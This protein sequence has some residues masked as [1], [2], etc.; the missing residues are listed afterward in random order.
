[1][2]NDENILGD[3]V[4][5]PAAYAISREDAE[6]LNKTPPDYSIY[7]HLCKRVH[8][9]RAREDRGNSHDTIH[10][11]IAQTKLDEF[12]DHHNKSLVDYIL[13]G[14][15]TNE[16]QTEFVKNE[17]IP[18]CVFVWKETPDEKLANGSSRNNDSM[19]FVESIF[20]LGVFNPKTVKGCYSTAFCK[21][22][23]VCL[24][25]KFDKEEMNL[26][27]ILLMKKGCTQ[28]ATMA[29]I[30]DEIYKILGDSFTESRQSILP[31][32][33]KWCLDNGIEEEWNQKFQKILEL[34][35]AEGNMFISKSMK[36]NMNSKR[37]EVKLFD[38]KSQTSRNNTWCSYLKGILSFKCLLIEFLKD[39]VFQPI[40]P[41]SDPGLAFFVSKKGKIVS[42]N[43]RIAG[44]GTAFLFDT[45]PLEWEEIGGKY[46]VVGKWDRANDLLDG[47]IDLNDLE[48]NLEED[49]FY[50]EEEQEYDFDL[51][52]MNMDLDEMDL[53]LDN[54]MEIHE[55]FAQNDLLDKDPNDEDFNPLDSL[56]SGRVL[57]NDLVRERMQNKS[58]DF[59]N[60]LEASIENGMIVR[61]FLRTSQ[62]NETA[63]GCALLAYMINGSFICDNLIDNTAIE[64]ILDTDCPSIIHD[65][66]RRLGVIDGDYMEIDAIHEHFI[67]ERENEYPT[68]KRIGGAIGGNILRSPHIHNA[69]Q[70]FEN[71]QGTV[72]AA[73][74]FHSH[75]VAIA[76]IE[77]GNKNGG[78]K[79]EY[80]VIDTLPFNHDGDNASRTRCKDIASLEIFLSSLGWSKLSN[81]QRFLG[82]MQNVEDLDEDI[83]PMEDD[84]RNFSLFFYNRDTTKENSNNMKIADNVDIDATDVSLKNATSKKKTKEC[85]GKKTKGGSGKKKKGG[86]GKKKKGGSGKKKKGGSGKKKK[87]VI[88]DLT[89]TESDTDM[90]NYS[91]SNHTADMDTPNGWTCDNCTYNLN[92]EDFH[93]CAMCLKRRVI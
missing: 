40:S 70:E 73:L 3:R 82:R 85:S 46:V 47:E 48:F 59:E 15:F 6:R 93:K 42:F 19:Y 39:R 78:V 50:N 81:D 53:D 10:R 51:D 49:S 86:S 54:E 14:K 72:G 67:T 63:N 55:E 56:D 35:F 1:M 60:S 8:I 90:Y 88:Q 28:M 2:T 29:N 66:R 76:R 4:F 38:A 37:F 79:Y 80:D 9:S 27:C 32:Y 34:T 16:Q 58:L 52:E 44:D 21:K 65:I 45:A 5:H 36:M 69:C 12:I 20:R 77:I 7:D 84:G 89:D 87:I 33:R 43:T 64:V 62:K 31:E 91:T 26:V 13:I 25:D 41:V 23:V 75:Y 18:L 74:Y 30:I 57:V 83:E 61:S 17:Y 11:H 22:E 71:L 92:P 68:M 24:L